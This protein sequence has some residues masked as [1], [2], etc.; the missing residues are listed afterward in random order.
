M[1]EQKDN[2]VHGGARPDEMAAGESASLMKE[3]AEQKEKA[4]A[5][6]AGWL[7]AQADLINFRRRNEQEREDSIKYGN[8]NLILKI[9][10]VLDDFERAV[11]SLPRELWDDAWVD[12]VKHISRKLRTIL[13]AAGL[14]AIEAVGEPFDPRV[15]EAVREAEG[16]EGIVLEEA[17]KGYRF[18]DKVVRPSK[19]IVGTGEGGSG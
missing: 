12:G 18:L 17:E 4:E 19:V 13:E 9:L 5:A 2:D 14:S 6:R 3:L 7:R 15:H 16:K 11:A 10:P 8:V 1:T